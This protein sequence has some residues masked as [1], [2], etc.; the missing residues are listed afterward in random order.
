MARARFPTAMDQNAR[1][2][3]GSTGNAVEIVLLSKLFTIPAVRLLQVKMEAG[4]GVM[5]APGGVLNDWP[6]DTVDGVTMVAA[7]V[8]GLVP[9]RVQSLSYLNR[10]DRQ[11]GRQKLLYPDFHQDQ[12]YGFLDL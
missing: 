11:P 5:P 7:Y 10:T 1:H 4:A 8:P 9:G 12:T 6:C 3:A 2:G